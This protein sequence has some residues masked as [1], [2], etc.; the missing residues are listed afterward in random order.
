MKFG[1]IKIQKNI[2]P[3]FQKAQNAIHLSYTFYYLILLHLSFIRLGI[4]PFNIQ[5]L[6]QRLGQILDFYQIFISSYD[7]F[8][9]F[10]GIK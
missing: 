10:S 6:L 9:T 8:I 7:D 2:W 3:N 5:S 1:K 4:S